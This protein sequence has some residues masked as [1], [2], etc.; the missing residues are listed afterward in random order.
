[1][2]DHLDAIRSRSSSDVIAELAMRLPPR[3]QLVLASRTGVKLPTSALRVQGNLVELSAS[4]LAMDGVEARSLLTELGLDVGSDLD[5]VMDRTEGWPV[6]LYLVALALKAGRLPSALPIGG[7]DRLFADYFR[8]D[9]LKHFSAARVAFLTRTSILDRLTGPLCDAVLETTGSAQVIERLEKANLLI[10]PLDRT[11]EWYRYHHLL[12]DFLHSELVRREPELVPELHTRAAEWFDTNDMPEMAVA[13]AQVAGDADLAARIV[14]RIGRSAYGSGRADTVIG[15][16]NWFDRTDDI[17]R[18]PTIAALGALVH[19]L[20]GNEREAERWSSVLFTGDMPDVDLPSTALVLRAIRFAGGT[21]QVRGDA[22]AARQRDAQHEWG[23]ATLCLEGFSHLWDGD[24]DQ[25]DSLFAQSAAIG[26]WYLGVPSVT[27][28]LGARAMIAIGRGDWDLAH[29]LACQS[30]E[31]IQEHSLE[32]YLTSGLTYAVATRCA[33]WRHDA[34]RARSLLA[35]ATN[36]RPLLGN[37]TAGV[38]VQTLLEL[39]RAHLELADVAGARLVL[40]EAGD[41]LAGRADVGL[42]AGQYKELKAHLHRLV[43]STVGASALTKAEVRLLPFLATYLS[44]PEI[45]D[46]LYVS[47]H[48]VKTQ[49]MSIYRKLGA[50]SRSEAVQRAIEA[51]YLSA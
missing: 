3:V 7:D 4:D 19:V 34:S 40:R 50:S 43:G 45:G 17:D 42:L 38:S 32:A 44:F 2:L 8:Q 21:A 6:G 46:R 28:A 5:D 47:R 39:T 23:A 9:V 36:I 33:L 51:G 49:A 14:S 18:Y 31:L 11:R 12:R 41:I 30:V 15:W 37:A 24:I 27:I 20:S 1:M 48:T 35:R 29:R 13:H 10:V 22:I 16:L 26:E 25:A